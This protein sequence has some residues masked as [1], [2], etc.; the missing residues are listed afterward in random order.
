MTKVV[1]VN[2]KTDADLISEHKIG[3]PVFGELYSRYSNLVL[4][5]CMKYLKNRADA[6]DAVSDIFQLVSEKLLV[7][8]VE[9]FKS[10][11]YTV[12][13]NHC[14]EKLRK[15]NTHKDKK[16]RAENM[17]SESIFHPDDVTDPELLKK[18][19]DCIEVLPPKQLKT[20]KM[21][22]FDKIAYKKIAAEMD[23]SWDKV[24]S[25]IQNGRRNLKN[26]IEKK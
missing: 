23:I 25:F 12:T 26:C 7:H 19:N 21:F 14:I 16:S 22:Y 24:R 15:V 4:G 10:W 9:Y 8:E 2:Q 11:L 3:N 1:Q 17:Y 13:R 6:E 5:S 18:L 20:I